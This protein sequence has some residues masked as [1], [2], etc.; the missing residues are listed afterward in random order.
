MLLDEWDIPENGDISPVQSVDAQSLSIKFCLEAGSKGVD[1]PN[2]VYHRLPGISGSN[3]SL[4]AESNRHLDNKELFNLGESDALTFGSLVH[5]MVLEP[6][7]VENNYCVMP[8]YDG[9]TTKGKEAKKQFISEN[10]GKIVIDKED[11]Q[12]ADNMTRN[13]NAICGDVIEQAIKERS[14]FVEIDGL[15]LKSRLDA[16]I[17]DV[18]D[19]Y[20]LKTIT[21]GTKE[22]SDFTLECHIK[23]LGYHRSAAFR[24]IV[25]R[26]LGKPVRDS[27]LIFCNT[28]PGNMVRV[29]KMHPDWI[30]GAEYDVL[31][32]LDHRR[33]YLDSGVDRKATII[34]DRFR[35]NT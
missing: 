20:D 22:F 27:Y 26:A 24:N 15:V 4:L 3:L 32:L 33:F 11:F 8:S 25:R 6:H 17:E 28:G 9:R 5:T 21:L 18:G 29:I 19:D 2:D 1:I 14:L 31:E 10:E 13:V 30:A 7:D 34:D 23:K 35:N 16:D 12:N